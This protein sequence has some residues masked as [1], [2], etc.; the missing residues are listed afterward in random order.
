MHVKRTATIVLGG[1]AL[2]AWLAGAATSNRPAS[3]PPLHR[4]PPI[5]ARGAA[6]AEEIARLRERLRPSAT[7]RAPGRNLFRFQA[8]AAPPV[9]LPAPV[10]PPIAPARAL[11]AEL[12]LRLSGIGEDP[13]AEG[14]VRI[15]FISGDGQLYVVKEGDLVTPRYRVS[16]ISADVVELI[17]TGDG[18]TRRLPLR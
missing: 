4:P 13:G 11:P 9:A 12:P 17:D 3:V 5:D 1:G 18:S 7:P 14:P 2:A 15:A 6:L 16:K 10:A 8:A